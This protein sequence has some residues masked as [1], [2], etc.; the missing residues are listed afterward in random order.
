[1]V[2]KGQGIE[3]DEVR[4][5]QIGDDIR[6]IDWNVT[7]RTGKPHVKKYI[8]ERELSVMILVDVSLSTQFGSVQHL[9]SQLAAEVSAL[10]ALSAIRNND[11]VGLIIFS[12]RIEKFIPPRK[13][14]QHVL[15]VIREILYFEPQG[16]STDIIQALD[17]LNRV[18]ARK[19][20][21]FLISDFFLPIKNPDGLSE[22]YSRLKRKLSVANQ[23]HDM[24][25]VSL[26]DPSELNLPDC[27]ML[28]FKDAETGE[29]FLVDTSDK[30]FRLTYHSQN[31]ERINQRARMFQSI[32][33][34]YIDIFT[35]ESYSDA[36]VKFFLKRR[37][38]RG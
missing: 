24:I 3:F 36:I 5:Y 20:I 9:K 18:T 30:Q 19:S 13:G 29:Q 33:M 17:Y 35:D 14:R 4:E 26:N 37:K 11:K 2:F 8:E 23:R 28:T 10:L 27:G 21:T 7:A 38:R 31:I 32:G 34:D 6:T 1:S 22:S 15:R 12:D 25:A 16:R